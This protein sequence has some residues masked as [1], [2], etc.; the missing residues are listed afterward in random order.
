MWYE[1]RYTKE[2]GEVSYAP[3]YFLFPNEQYPLPPWPYAQQ[4]KLYSA[5]IDTYEDKPL[6]VVVKQQNST[7]TSIQT[8]NAFTSGSTETYAPI[9]MNNYYGWVTSVN[10]QNLD[11]HLNNITIVYYGD[12][13]NPIVKNHSIPG[14]ASASYYSPAQGLNFTVGSAVITSAYPVAVVVN[15]STSTSPVRSCSYSASQRGSDY[16]LLPDIVHNR[17]FGG[18]QN[19]VSSVNLQNVGDESEVYHI[20]L[21]TASGSVRVYYLVEIQPGGWFSL[22]IPNVVGPTSWRGHGE[23]WSIGGEPVVVVVNQSASIANGDM[24]RSYQGVNR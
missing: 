9:I 19:W 5:M 1:T 21:R 14:Y 17:D 22:Y 7:G 8:Y 13:E 18:D 11:S 6:A 3:W 12:P 20:K 16:V 2:D 4:N 15:Q 23:V 10:V 24:S